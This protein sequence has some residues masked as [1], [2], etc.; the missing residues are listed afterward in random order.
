MKETQ[1]V[2]NHTPLTEEHI[3][4]HAIGELAPPSCQIVIVD[5]DQQWPELFVREADRIRAVLGRRAL[6]I[7][8]VGSTSVPGL[9]AKPVIDALL[10]VTDSGDED[11]YLPSLEAAGYLLRI[12]ESNW[13]EHRMFNGPDTEIN[14]HVFSSECPE[15]DR[16]LTFRDWLRVDA[17]DRD[18]YARAKLA[19]AQKKW[20]SVQDYADAKTSVIEEIIA[21]AQ[22]DRK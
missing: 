22:S 18:V 19:L 9:V 16:M 8:H 4:S 11:A 21:R 10:T 12:R 13:Y 1:P 17:A 5:Y 15:I 20:K 3:R 6:R 7:E 2:A 14:L